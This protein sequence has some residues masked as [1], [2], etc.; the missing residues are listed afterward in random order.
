MPGK[1]YADLLR[2]VKETVNP[3][4]IRVEVKNITKTRNGEL[5]LTVQN[6][7]DKAEV[8]KKELNKRLPE[9]T[10][11]VLAKKKV[12]HVRGMDEI[13]TV[14]EIRAAVCEAINTNADAFEVRAL[15]PAY[16]SRQ[17]VTLVMLETYANRLIDAGK[18]KI[19]WTI[20]RVSERKMDIRCYKCWEHGHTKLQ[21]NGPNREHCC[22]KCS[23]EGHR[24][25]KCP[26]NAYCIYCKQEG[27]Q[28]GNRGCKKYIERKAQV[29]TKQNA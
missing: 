18:L 8:L 7:M 20:C 1:S 22:L 9:A 28:S 16:G 14:E 10:T 26:N 23:K 12:L 29:L 4:N 11:T 24:A 15:R 3:T 17:N 6:G 2:K 27:H 5:V 21:C 25:N 19:G 13:T